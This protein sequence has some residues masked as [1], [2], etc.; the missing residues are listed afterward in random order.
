MSIPKAFNGADA[1]DHFH[2]LHSKDALKK[3]KRMRCVFLFAIARHAMPCASRVGSAVFGGVC[4]RRA[5]A[6]YTDRFGA[7]GIDTGMHLRAGLWI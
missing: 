3:L 4:A 6:C 2:S 7:T 5:A 1:T